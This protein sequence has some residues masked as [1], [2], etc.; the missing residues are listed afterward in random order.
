MLL[1][2]LVH[3]FAT[4]WSDGADSF[5]R[6]IGLLLVSGS[7]SSSNSSIWRAGSGILRQAAGPKLGGRPGRV[8][9]TAHGRIYEASLPRVIRDE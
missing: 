2:C 3:A 4:R 9:L 5:T 1:K 6:T 7:S 8:R